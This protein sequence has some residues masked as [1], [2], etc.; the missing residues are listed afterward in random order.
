MA[1]EPFYTPGQSDGKPPQSP[2]EFSPAKPAGPDPVSP[3]PVPE[4]SSTEQHAQIFAFDASTGQFKPVEWT[5]GKLKVDATIEA[6]IGE[7]HATIDN[8]IDEDFT[9]V[10]TQIVRDLGSGLVSL[11]VQT[12]GVRTK[13][14]IFTRDV[15]GRVTNIQEVLV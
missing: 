10:Q 5:A 6:T 7:V 3:L 13:N 15:V 9:I 4:G 1:D 2:T 12:D 8:W 14:T 11:V